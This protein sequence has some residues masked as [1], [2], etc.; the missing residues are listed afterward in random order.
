[1]E[2]VE[3]GILLDAYPTDEFDSNKVRQNH[4]IPEEMSRDGR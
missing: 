4:I 3:S 2:I 1:M